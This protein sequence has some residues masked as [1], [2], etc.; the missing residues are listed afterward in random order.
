[1]QLHKTTYFRYI[2]FLAI[3]LVIIGCGSSLSRRLGGAPAPELVEN[4]PH[5]VT[6][7]PWEIYGFKVTALG[8]PLDSPALIKGDETIQT[9][10]NR[11][12]ALAFYQAALNEKLS[13]TNSTE[14][15]ERIAATQLSL[16]K[17]AATIKALSDY[18]RYTK[19]AESEVPPRSAVLFGYAYGR[20]NN[21]A[22]SLAWFS[23]A[24]R[25]SGLPQT[26]SGA[27]R[28]GVKFVARNLSHD[29]LS[30]LA[31]TWENDEFIRSCLGEERA[32]RASSPNQPLTNSYQVVYDALKQDLNALVA[33]ENKGREM[34]FALELSG[35]YKSL[36]E[37]TKRGIET[38]ARGI[39][40]ETPDGGEP[41]TL[42]FVDAAQPNAINEIFKKVP[43]VVVGPLLHEAATVIEPQVHGV[44]LISLAKRPSETADNVIRFAPSTELQVKHLF[45]TIE[46]R[47][48]KRFAIV[49]TD[50]QAFREY[51]SLV[52]EEIMTR[53]GEI[54]FDQIYPK[55]NEDAVIEVG[56]LLEKARFDAVFFADDAKAAAVF[57]GNISPE[58]RNLFTVLGPASWSETEVQRA[59]G[60]LDRAI[61]PIPY[62]KGGDV[63][64]IQAFNVSYLGS[65]GTEPDYIAA[66]G[67]DLGTLVVSALKLQ[68]SQGNISVKQALSSLGAYEGLTGSCLVQ[69]D[70]LVERTFRVVQLRDGKIVGY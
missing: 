56:K 6:R 65:Y 29:E 45:A 16:D 24:R 36:G 5:V 19:K 11:N 51:E 2:T 21:P 13:P 41:L 15:V 28:E 69:P 37:S 9:T 7:M 54:V 31:K 20:L 17:P 18:F 68:I 40:L 10:G 43:G 61:W 23:K 22:Q 3:C 27:A 30:A 63:P 48:F 32:H 67:F 70:G 25:D 46:P 49:G 64:A 47:R 59:A 34:V 60:V 38:A 55:G 53:G 14:A 50:L 35:Q 42:T 8:A 33:P 66:Q 62:F 58:E 4:R 39:G 26:A 12:K 44:Q 52:R 57:F 1:M